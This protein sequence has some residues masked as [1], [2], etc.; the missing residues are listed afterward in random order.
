M[1]T[2]TGEA[3]RTGPFGLLRR[4]TSGP[5]PAPHRHRDVQ[6]GAFRASVLGAGDGLITNVSLVLGVAGGN[7]AGGAVRLAGIAGMLA[8]ACSMAAG[9]LVSV[10]AQQ[11]LVE[12]EIAVER[13]E[14][15]E[16]PEAEQRELA[17]MYRARGV[18]PDDAE[19]VARILSSNPAVALDT[20]TRLELGVDPNQQGQAGRAAVASF[21][22]FGIGA[23]LPLLPWFFTHGTPAVLASI[24]IGA[25]VAVVLGAAIGSFSGR[26]KT[27]V[28]LRQ[29]AAA[30]VSAG[31]TF[32]VGALFGVGTS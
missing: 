17:A 3:V 24:A 21:L 6:G 2:V 18:T 30:I 4:F 7:S 9:E 26:G 32:G 23:L 11:E 15:A 28:A 1:A 14:L 22:S 20:H 12:R 8:G 10:R 5:T 25:V 29:L 16:E 19:I 13:A 31:I 27:R